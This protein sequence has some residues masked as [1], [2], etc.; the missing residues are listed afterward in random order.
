VTLL[1]DE[2]DRTGDGKVL[3]RLIRLEVAIGRAAD[4]AARVDKLE[5]EGGGIDR[6]L[7]IGWR[8]L[9]AR[10]PERARSVAE[11]ILKLADTAGG[12][13]LAGKALA[14]L[15]LVD[16]ALAQLGKVPA[17]A[18]QF[19]AAQSLVG[20]LL[21]DRGRY[22]EAADAL[23]K[24]I[25]T[26]GGGE[27]TPGDALQD[28][29]AQVQQRAGNGEQGVKLLEHALHDRPGSQELAFALGSAYERN[30]QWERAVELVRGLLK[31]DPDSV[32]AMNFIGYALAEQGQKLDEARRLLER[33]LQLR[34]MSGEIADSLGWVYV[35]LGRLDDAERLLVRADRL[36]P[37][38]PEILQHLG[39]LYVKKSDRPRAVDAYKRALEHNPEERA[40]HA[41]EEQLLLLETGRMASGSGAPGSR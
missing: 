9:D 16:D 14:E 31:R 12:H 21:R 38:D 18:S 22:R 34:P 1:S 29:L 17:R 24:A 37:E 6:R 25:G 15:G 36:T 4:A 27:G 35:K 30:G 40:R 2:Y 19:V 8:W 5:D 10:Q 11:Q 7:W 39:E 3:E 32:Q 13:L 23:V 33:A 20:R 26:V 28:L 41:I